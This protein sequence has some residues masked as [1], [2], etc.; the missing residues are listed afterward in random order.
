MFKK[1]VPAE[2]SNLRGFSILL[3]C[4]FFDLPAPKPHM[5][6]ATFSPVADAATRP[7]SDGKGL[8]SLSAESNHRPLP[9]FISTGH[10]QETLAPCLLS[11]EGRDTFGAERV[12]RSAGMGPTSLAT[13][14]ETQGVSSW[15]STKVAIQG[16]TIFAKSQIPLFVFIVQY[17]SKCEISRTSHC[18]LKILHYVGNEHTPSIPKT[19]LQYPHFMQ[20]S[21]ERAQPTTRERKP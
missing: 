17:S 5:S 14:W 16:C 9:L 18:I 6:P 11:C 12:P 20:V 10:S 19:R 21:S 8:W 13:S 4:L 2:G 3:C 1:L 15:L 7:H